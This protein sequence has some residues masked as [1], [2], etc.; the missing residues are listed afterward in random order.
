[1]KRI[2]LP[3]LLALGTFAP[4]ALPTPRQLVERFDAAQARANTFQ[5][6]FTL[7]IRRAMLKTPT[8]TRG[9]LYLQGTEFAHFEFAPPEDLV[10]H[11]TPKA[12]VSYSPGAGEG[13]MLKIGVIRNADRRFLGLGQKLSLLEDYFGLAL[14]EAKDVPGTILVN[15]TPRS[16]SVKRRMQ[17]LALWVDAESYLPRQIRWVERSGDSWHLELGALSI[18]QPMPASVAGFK[19]PPGIKLRPEFSF[20]ATRKK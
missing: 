16:L 14:S 19:V 1:M 11:L 5:A 15:L 7:T 10:L 6:P 20:F 18:N 12:L 8:V 3:A 4:A 9:T 13:E 17:S 2:L